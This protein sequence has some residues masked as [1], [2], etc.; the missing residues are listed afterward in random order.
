M[1]RPG[2]A[3]TTANEG[4]TRKSGG[5]EVD[6]LTA[7]LNNIGFGVDLAVLGWGMKRIR[8]TFV[9]PVSSMSAILCL[10]RVF[11]ARTRQQDHTFCICNFGVYSRERFQLTHFLVRQ[12]L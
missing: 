3:D 4:R 7:G 10:L 9:L 8:S 1:S 11:V 2:N 12:K 6:E 5:T